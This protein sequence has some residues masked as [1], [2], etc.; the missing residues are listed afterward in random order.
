MVL[1]VNDKIG[2][3]ST[4]S[5]YGH[6]SLECTST[7]VC[8]PA[9]CAGT[10]AQ[11]LHGRK[12]QAGIVVEDVEKALEDVDLFEGMVTNDT[13]HVGRNGDQLRLGV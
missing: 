6:I 1:L 3:L 2:L 10:V 7:T 11:D 12:K 9:A 4:V 13:V 5:Q 8:F